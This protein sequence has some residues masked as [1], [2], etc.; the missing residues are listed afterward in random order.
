[1]AKVLKT[2]QEKITENNHLYALPLTPLFGCQCPSYLEP[3]FMHKRKGTD[4]VNCTEGAIG[5]NRFQ[6]ERTIDFQWMI[7]C[8]VKKHTF[9]ASTVQAQNEKS[10]FA[11]RSDPGGGNYPPTNVQQP[12]LLPSCVYVNICELGV[13]G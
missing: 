2:L 9:V 1:M 13:T 7:S 5:S 12:R 8:V 10:V 4:E 3:K 6:D 11:V